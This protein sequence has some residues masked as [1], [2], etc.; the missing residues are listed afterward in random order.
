MHVYSE[1]IRVFVLEVA[2]LDINTT[3]W[4]IVSIYKV[5]PQLKETYWFL[6]QPRAASYNP[7]ISLRRTEDLFCFQCRVGLLDHHGWVTNPQSCCQKD[8]SDASH[9]SFLPKEEA[10]M[11]KG[12]AQGHRD[13]W[14]QPP[15]QAHPALELLTTH[16]MDQNWTPVE[17]VLGNVR[18]N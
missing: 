1:L 8:T 16:Q 17:L 5:L 3:S 12:L 13:V 10:R 15:W 2:P 18:M 11:V 4:C 14:S 9:L 6:L 7:S